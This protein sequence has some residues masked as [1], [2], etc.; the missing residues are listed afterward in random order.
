MPIDPEKVIKVS[1]IMIKEGSSVKTR[2]ID[3]KEEAIKFAEWIDKSEWERDNN[4]INWFGNVL[5]DRGKSDKT[6]EDLYNLFKEKKN[7][8]N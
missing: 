8:N 4:G 7:E 6:T 1:P 3:P 5:E 2:L